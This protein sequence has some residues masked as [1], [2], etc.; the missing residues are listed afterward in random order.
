MNIQEKRELGYEIRSL[1]PR[2]IERV[3]EIII[4]N[5]TKNQSNHSNHNS[6]NNVNILEED[7]FG[8]DLDKMDLKTL[9]EV[10]NYIK[11]VKKKPQE[12]SVK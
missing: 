5:R 7:S 12:Y 3:A 1:T 11:Q 4:K 9:R 8:V 10:Q 6:H 2:H